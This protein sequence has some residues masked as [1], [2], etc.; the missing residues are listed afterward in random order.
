MF[1]RRRRNAGAGTTA[2]AGAPF[3]R[4]LLG[5]GAPSNALAVRRVDFRTP[6]ALAVATA[7]AIDGMAMRTIQ[8]QV[9]NGVRHGMVNRYAGYL[10][11]PQR[12]YGAQGI[13]NS[14]SIRLASQ[15]QGLPSSHGV[16]GAAQTPMQRLLEI[17]DEING[18][19]T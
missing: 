14:T 17:N 11:S 10:A 9:P 1:R 7:A 12:F 4:S 19:I 3:G 16:T 8:G 6:A 2:R 15:R 18:L 5:S 13:G